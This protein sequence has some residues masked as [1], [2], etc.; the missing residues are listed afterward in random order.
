MTS[1]TI[2]HPGIHAEKD[3]HRPAI[4]MG[5]SGTRV[6]FSELE[7]RSR[8]VA[9]VF[10]AQGLKTGDAIAILLENRAEYLIICWAAQR[11]GL[12]FTPI[13]WHLKMEEAAYVIKDCGAKLLVASAGLSDLACTLAADLPRSLLK[14]SVGGDVPGYSPLEVA[15][16]V[17]P[18]QALPDESEGMVMFYSSG[19]TGYP[20]G[21]KRKLSGNPFGTP[22]VLEGLLRMAYGFDENTIYLCPGPLYHAAPLAYSMAAQRLGGCVVVME[23]FDPEAAL[24]LMERHKV[25]HAQFVPTHFIRM[26]HLDQA[27]RSKYDLST[28]KAAIHAAA[29][30][31]VEVKE[32][33]LD[34]WGPKIFEYYAG[35]EGNGFCIITAQDWLTHKG[36]VGRSM[37]GPVH[38]VGPDGEELPPG[39][40][41]LIY[42]EGTEPFE[43]H[44]APEKTEGAYHAKGWS[45][46]GDIG[47]LDE[48]GFLYL[49]DRKSHMII[50]GGVN[51]YPQEI[52]NALALYPAIRDVAVIGVPNDE[53][54]EEVK[55]VVELRDGQAGNEGLAQDI[56]AYCRT[57]LAHYKCPKS[58]DF[59]EELPRL[60]NGKLMKRDLRKRYW[61]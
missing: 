16:A 18:A 58:V 11:A 19:T 55:A 36:S 32:R 61:Q 6:S 48:D 37:L 25:T 29:P 46:L 9:Q 50:S 20:K 44:N 54:G 21:I 17:Q 27:V 56:I 4:I 2:L 7:T 24:R 60:P 49:T 8:Q 53:F 28:L 3:P 39:Q 42:F 38:I 15:A 34:W 43:Y 12:Y 13:N 41:G 59:V 22:G 57:R 30:C 52:E 5:E 40:E 23:K 45:T 31:P 51:I 26:L 14:Y 47:F 10:R 35:S 33:M 1:A